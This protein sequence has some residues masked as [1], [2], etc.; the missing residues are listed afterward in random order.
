MLLCDAIPTALQTIE[1]SKQKALL[2]KR[3]CEVLLPSRHD[4]I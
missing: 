2:A 3:H 4:I 1:F